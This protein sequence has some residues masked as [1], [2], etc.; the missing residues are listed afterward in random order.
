MVF[1]ACTSTTYANTDL[2]VRH[3]CRL[4]VIRTLKFNSRWAAKLA[5]QKARRE[6]REQAQRERRAAEELA[7]QEQ[8]ER[9]KVNP[10]GASANT[11]T[12]GAGA[13]LGGMLFGGASNPFAPA[14]SEVRAEQ[15]DPPADG[16][17]SEDDSEE[18]ES[19][20]L[21]EELAIKSDLEAVPKG[22]SWVTSSTK[23]P[24]LYLNT[25]PEPSSSSLSKKLTAQEADLLKKASTAAPGEAGNFDENELEGF[26]KEGYEKMLLD[27]IDDTFERFVK[28]VSVEG[29]QVVRYEFGG[30]PIPFH[31]RGAV[32]SML[33]PKA[34]STDPKAGEQVSVTRSSFKTSATSGPNT[35]LR[36][37]T[38]SNIPP[39]PA[40]GSPRVFEAQLMPN[41]INTLKADSILAADGTLLSTQP[42]DTLSEDARRKRDIERALG[43]ALP[44]APSAEGEA[45]KHT[46]AYL[47]SVTGLVWSTAFVFVCSKDCCI[48]SAGSN[49]ECW[50]EEFIAA[51]FEDE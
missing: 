51:Q 32:Y 27:G 41:I 47:E 26:A 50:R 2:I 39:C 25:I 42:E 10:F 23:Y 49:D 28:R 48:P 46:G 3:I 19:E 35:E 1:A 21:A 13:G 20:R 11:S 22:T 17:E 40:C 9:S 16:S 15:Q 43:R 12:T 5:K 31:A 34:G 6:A 45:I 38:D 30:E 24:A 33:W 4:R 18:S 37:Y 8:Q 44:Q 29:R 36:D 14:P 7:R